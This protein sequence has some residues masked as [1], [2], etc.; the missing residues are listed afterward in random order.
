[1]YLLLKDTEEDVVLGV[2]VVLIELLLVVLILQKIYKLR[3]CQLIA[4]IPPKN[5]R[6][7]IK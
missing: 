6:K 3:K 4:E 5:R 2:I 7:K 1:M